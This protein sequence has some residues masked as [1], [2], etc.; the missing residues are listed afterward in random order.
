M[1]AM[2]EGVG[3]IVDGLLR[4]LRQALLVRWGADSYLVMSNYLRQCG[5]CRIP[6][7][8]K[9]NM[10]QSDPDRYSTHK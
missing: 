6:D 10:K 9:L 8:K 7:D 5:R 4:V 3:V 1:D 2:R